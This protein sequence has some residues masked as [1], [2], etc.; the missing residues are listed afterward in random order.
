MDGIIFGFFALSGVLFLG[1]I[2]YFL[3][4]HKPGMYPPKKVLRK[5]A[6]VLASSGAFCL[7]LGVLFWLVN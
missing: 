2:H 3:A 4:T 5:R 7:I 6:G 1:M